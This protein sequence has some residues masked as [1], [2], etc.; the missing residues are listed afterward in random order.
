[1]CFAFASASVTAPAGGSTEFNVQRLSTETPYTMLRHSVG[2][3]S[4]LRTGFNTAETPTGATNYR[5]CAF[6][7]GRSLARRR[8]RG[9]DSIFRSWS[10]GFTLS[11]KWYAL[12]HRDAMQVVS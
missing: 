5:L 7:T 9:I 2:F 6:H 12:S 3:S 8:K 4:N 11:K 10:L 1:M